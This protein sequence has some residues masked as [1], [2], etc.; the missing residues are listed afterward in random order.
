MN[1]PR[2]PSWLKPWILPFWNFGHRLTLRT[3]EYQ[4]AVRHRR[5]GHCDVCGR[6]APWLYQRRVVPARLEELWELS[7][8]LARALAAKE[9][10]S[11]A[12][13]Q[14]KL[15]GRRLARVI[16]DT[17]PVG[18]P[19]APASSLKEWVGTN[20]AQSLRVAE[21]NRIDGLHD[22]LS[23][24]PRLAY[25]E[26]EPEGNAEKVRI[27]DLTRLTYPDASF[28]L[29][30][31]SES[32]EH[33]PDLPAALSEIHRVLDTGG[34]HVFT[35]PLLPGVPLTSARSV[36]IQGEVKHLLP[37]IRHPGG[38]IGYPVFTEFG[39]DLPEILKRAGFEVEMRFG[40]IRGDDIAQVW[41][42]RKK[43]P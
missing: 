12:W 19:P 10:S 23:K 38:D 39:A 31:T 22:V 13:C 21:I 5:F 32:L 26:F 17:Y 14:A 35:L 18:T 33:V 3:G 30:L 37:E 28:D 41:I 40:P 1:R 4:G 11:C 43:T 27:E 25:S 42:C 6:F 20:E 24:L 36:V 34:C 9:S 8:Q 2:P 16:L 29:V 15:R 7:P